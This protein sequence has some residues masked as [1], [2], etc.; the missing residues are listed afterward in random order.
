MAAIRENIRGHPNPNR[1]RPVAATIEIWQAPVPSLAP[2]P[3]NRSCG[4]ALRCDGSRRLTVT[5][6]TN[7]IVPA[8]LIAFG[9][10]TFRPESPK[11]NGA[12]KKL[13]SSKARFH[14]SRRVHWSLYDVRLDVGQKSRRPSLRHL[15]QEPAGDRRGVCGC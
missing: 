7:L 11:A 9:N 2:P 3:A 8:P 6:S 10:R 4:P 12:Q 1:R 13:A 14:F 5:Q 15:L